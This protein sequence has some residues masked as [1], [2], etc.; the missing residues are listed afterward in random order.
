M[1]P[2]GAG[3]GTQAVAL[4][5]ALGVPQIATGDIFRANVT[6]GTDLGREAKRYLDAGD[7]VPDAVTNAM[8]RARLRTVHQVRTLDEIL[9]E[10]DTRLDA[11]VA[12][13][14]P[15][16]ELV[17]RLVNRAHRDGR[18]DDTED[19]IRHRQNVYAEQT[20]PL[21]DEY[22]RRG[23]LLEI[24]GIGEVADVQARV[25]AAL[26]AVQTATVPTDNG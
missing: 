16:E 10:H 5:A 1:G 20:A 4:S 3:K 2:P 26:D 9:A 17:H 6:A 18:S 23:I 13:Q 22:S 8:V 24:D 15:A 25:M 14:V 19:V 11:V 7:Y 21:L 12:L